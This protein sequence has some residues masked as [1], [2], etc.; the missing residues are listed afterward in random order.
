[1][2]VAESGAILRKRASEKMVRSVSGFPEGTERLE[3]LSD[4][5]TAK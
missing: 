4:S 3:L 2:Q 1:M 5:G